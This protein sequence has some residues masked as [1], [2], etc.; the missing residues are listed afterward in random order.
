MS[1]QL[2]LRMAAPSMVISLLLFASGS[3]GAWYVQNLQKSTAATM[4]LDM[5]TNHA[6]QQLVLSVTDVRS[7]LSEFLATG[8]ESHL[9]AA[10]VRCGDLERCLRETEKLVDDENEKILTGRIRNG[11]ERLLA[12]F[13]RIASRPMGA[14]TKPIVA[15]LYNEQVVKG[16]LAPAKELLALEEKLNRQ[17][18]DKNQRIAT[19]MALTL[20]LI[21]AVGAATGVVAGFG[22]SRRVTR[23]IVE[24]H[25][26][27]RAASGKLE[28]V[29]GPI[30]VNPAAGIE[31]IDAILRKMT[32]QITTVVDRLQRSQVDVLRGEQMAALGQMAAGLAHELRN[33]LTAMKILIQNA[34]KASPPNVGLDGA[35][36]NRD[37]TVLEE[38]TTRLERSL[39]TFLDFARPPALEKRPGDLCRAIEQTMDLIRARADQQKVQVR[40]EFVQR[41]LMLEAD[42]EQLRQLFL[43]LTLNALDALP[44]GGCIS[45]TAKGLEVVRGSGGEAVDCSLSQH[46]TTSAPHVL[47]SWIAIVVEDNGPGIAEDLVDRIFTPYV[48]TKDSGLGL[49]L[50]MCRQIVQ[51][52]GGQITAASRPEGGAAFTVQLPS[53]ILAL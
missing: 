51:S 21:G 25:V 28:E 47:P 1:H 49:G 10:K 52:H 39:N 2:T 44:Q 36:T 8:N 24:L 31:G 33:P 13:E 9:E 4:Q 12:S 26:P 38:E 50:A 22:I 6:V 17:S 19:Q 20:W 18:G 27:I 16:V 11:Y 53:F 48:S 15:E 35:L 23:S 46:L 41:P 7:E 29:I 30:D 37:L 34:V 5:A 42:H 3:L 32:G 45:I 40:C 14:T 43:N